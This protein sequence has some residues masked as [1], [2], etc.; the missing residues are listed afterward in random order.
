VGTQST[1][2]AVGR[3]RWSGS[4]SSSIRR[5]DRRQ[6][7]GAGFAWEVAK[8]TTERDRE[9]VWFLYRHRILTT[10]QVEVLFF[11]SRRRCQDRLLF[12]YRHRVADRFYPPGPFRLGKPQAHWLLDDVGAYLV[13]AR[14][15]KERGELPWDRQRDYAAHRQL[16]HRLEVNQFAC[17]LVDASRRDGRVWVSDWMAGSEA[18]E[19]WGD[20]RRGVIPDAVFEL[21]SAGGPIELSLEWDRDTEPLS[22]LEDKCARYAAAL[23]HVPAVRHVCFVVPGERRLTALY[24]RVTGGE[25]ASRLHPGIRIWGTTTT[26][27]DAAGPLGRIWQPLDRSG[28]TA[29]LAQFDPIESWWAYPPEQALGRRWQLP[30]EQRWE[31]LSP[32]G[33]RRPGDRHAS[34]GAATPGAESSPDVERASTL[35]ERRAAID[36]EARIDA[37]RL[38]RHDT[39]QRAG[40]EWA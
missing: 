22:T 14:L 21:G 36:A 16:A 7:V 29:S 13:A 23:R 25:V 17:D 40:G 37:D 6:R 4:L 34:K 26:A 5:S 18:C 12:L 32:L 39:D 1:G 10:G 15:G 3:Q 27:I 30:L 11:S 20:Q 9:L 8:R 24:A 28:G 2:L 35:G 31:L 19:R 33:T 38:T